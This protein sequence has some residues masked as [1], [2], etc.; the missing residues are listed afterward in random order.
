MAFATNDSNIIKVGAVPPGTAPTPPERKAPTV[1]EVVRTLEQMGLALGYD[2]LANEPAKTGPLPWDEATG[3]RA[4]TEL[5]DAELYALLQ[6]TLGLKSEKALAC[7]TTI[8][9]HRHAYDPLTAM[10]DGIVWDGTERAGTLLAKYLGV[11]TMPYTVAAEQVFFCGGIERAYRPGCKFDTTLVLVGPG[12]IGK[13]TFGR[14]L[15]LKD[16][17]FTDSIYDF[18]NI[19]GTGEILRGK[20]IVE[21][22]ELS[23]ITGR[24]LE[25]VKAGITRQTD[26]FR[27]AYGRR[28]ADFQRRAVFIATTNTV[29]FIAEKSSGARRFL[30]VLCGAVPPTGSVFSREFARDAA[31]AWAEV[32][33]WRETGDPRFSLAL[34]PDMEIEAARQREGFLEDDPRVEAVNEYLDSNRDHPVCTRE[35]ADRALHVEPTAK[36]FKD[37]SVIL[38]DQCPG[39][40][41]DG[42]RCCG[43]YNKQRCWVYRP[44]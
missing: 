10:I 14:R 15:A 18:G 6:G 5:D 21:L 11:K 27:E 29:G 41:Y 24:S 31:Q 42:K 2:K 4:W 13:S 39:W 33:T 22:S 40:R 26:T 17:F 43:L 23:G 37:L 7:A 1:N 35:L 20:W 32:R 16:K 44:E 28:S 34:A 30:P 38:T 36:L 9:S 3:T 25:A 8:Y 12:G 19:K